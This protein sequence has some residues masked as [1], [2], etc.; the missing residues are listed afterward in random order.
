MIRYKAFFCACIILFPLTFRVIAQE[1]VTIS[2]YVLDEQ[3]RAI[4]LVNI[5]DIRTLKNAST[6]IN[7]FYSITLPKTDTVIMRYS[8]LSY[9]TATRI[10]PVEM[11]NLRVNVIMSISAR[12]LSEITVKGQQRRTNSLETLDASK[13]RMI[14][15]P[16]GGS[17]EA[18]LVTFAGVN[19]NNELS[20]QYSVRGG[21]YDE[22]LVYVNGT[23]VYR[24]LLIR[25]GQQEGLSFI[26]PE[27]V[28]EVK[29]SAGGFD[30]SYGDKM[31]S[32]LDIKY[33]KPKA[34]EAF[35]SLSLLGANLYLGQ[36]SKNG[37]FTQIHGF[38]YKT[39]S[40]LLGTLDTKG[41][42]KPSFIDYQNYLT[43]K[44]SPTT[45]LSLLGN[46]S[47]NSYQFIPEKKET[48]FGTFQK[49]Y[50]FMVYFDGKEKDLFQTSFAS[51][52]LNKTLCKQI[53]IGLQSSAFQTN[54]QENYDITGQYWLS[55]TPIKNNEKD[56]LN[57]SLIGV[58]TYHE[59]A[60]NSLTATVFNITHTGNFKTG[61]HSG[62]WGLGYQREKIHDNLR[63][64]EMR[65]SS[66]YSMP[67]SDKLINE[68]YFMK[69]LVDMESNRIT[70]YVLD[71]WRFRKES[72][73]FVV[74]GGVRGNYWDFNNET[75]I[76]PRLSVA[77]LPSW[78]KDFTFRFAT[79]VYY[80]A[81]FYKELRD[82]TTI[83]GV[84]QIVLNHN[85]KA[86]K[87]IHYIAGM[88][89]HFIWVD[90]PFK[91][92]A[93][94]YYKDMSNLIPYTVDNVR[95]RYMG[96]NMAD[97]YTAGLDMKLFGEF[98]PG[99]DSW[100][101]LSLM[102]SRETINGVTIPRPN[103]QRYNISVFFQ[104]Y[105]PN[106]PKLTMNL[107]LIWAD[108]LPFGPP[109]SDKSFATLRMPA[110]RRIDIGMSRVFTAGEDKCMQKGILRN[111][112]KFWIGVDCFN[113]LNTKNVD[114]Y[115]WVTDISNVQYAV[116]NY[117]TMMQLN[118]RLAAE[119]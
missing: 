53:R 14:P 21:N 93:E 114:S 45:E 18:L 111:L 85:I 88:D 20:S 17:I 79:G 23:E 81:P 35:G 77:F 75:L 42:Y 44:I 66:G 8:C 30:A 49:K 91:L 62:Q 28:E 98:V 67:Y 5:S 71:T 103:E 34:F 11:K 107:K 7:G 46:F 27:M 86:Q 19:S 29:F 108:G 9:Q 41:E 25:A 68:V 61:Q 26:N 92:T 116:P 70:G 37:K 115:Y 48:E 43:W 60:R 59:H 94:T 99:T 69:S 118:L 51:V 22:N 101:S 106:Y 1:T 31:S 12:N 87:T 105:F 4:E 95:I 90:R 78:K 39:N 2:G 52:A 119:F 82:T 73:L 84:T 76:S 97:G 80:Q 83:N 55:E 36:S 72:G 96:K 117:L 74:T 112:K 65:D 113:L 38:R 10:I 104:D 47:R 24:P 64:W 15:D 109:D 100:I 6:D 33:K 102:K 56:T 50:S 32:V 89:Y 63:E 16:S 57:T 110:Y 40:Y 54:E 58:G 3:S 13:I